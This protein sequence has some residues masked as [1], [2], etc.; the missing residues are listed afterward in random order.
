MAY[1]GNPA[2]TIEIIKKHDFI[3]KKRYGQNF[4]IDTHVLDKIVEAADISKKDIVI[5][6]G[7][8]I[9]SLTQLLCER[10]AKVIAVEIDNKLI[11]ILRDTMRNYNNIEIINSDVL[12][13]NLGEIIK[14]ENVV[15]RVKIVANL[16][17]YVTTPI[18][19]KLLEDK[20][21]I[22]SITVMVQKEVAERMQAKPR[23]KDYGAL[24]L[25]VEYYTEAKIIA[26]VPPNCFIPR[27][28]VASAV[29][30]LSIYKEA[31]VRVKDYKLMF[32]LIRAAFNQRRKTLQNGLNNALDIYYNKGEIINA[33]EKLELST[34]IRGEELSLKQFAELSDELVTYK[35]ENT[36]YEKH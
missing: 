7:P 17:Y 4:L 1:L 22:D 28:K 32:K 36:V 16:P 34:K 20:L 8:G 14:R 30:R 33:I 6:I 19:M 15:G 10:A 21:N 2:N 18:V 35:M 23:T 29:I 27:P 13:L 11:P 25:A 3:C 26:Y 5:E 31:P 24:S 12:K 9:G